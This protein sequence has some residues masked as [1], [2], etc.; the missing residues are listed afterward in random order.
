MRR[1]S[2]CDTEPGGGS[3]IRFILSAVWY[4]LAKL[5]PIRPIA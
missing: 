4:S 5:S 2:F 1:L 3:D